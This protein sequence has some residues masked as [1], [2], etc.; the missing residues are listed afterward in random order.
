MTPLERYDIYTQ[1]ANRSVLSETQTD[2]K[3][4]MGSREI[5]EG[6]T[7]WFWATLDLFN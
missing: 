6:T 5:I 4:F 2:K 3:I 1:T 7:S